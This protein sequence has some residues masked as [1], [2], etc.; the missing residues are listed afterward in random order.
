M[1]SHLFSALVGFIV[2]GIL[3][4]VVFL[5]KQAEINAIVSRAQGKVDTMELFCKSTLETAKI[6]NKEK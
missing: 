4:F 5:D 1:L 6:I 2:A 3:C